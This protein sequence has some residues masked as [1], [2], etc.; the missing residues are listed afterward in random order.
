VRR[1]PASSLAQFSPAIESDPPSLYVERHQ[2]IDW[3]AYERQARRLHGRRVWFL[4][5]HA[6]SDE[7]ERF[8]KVAFPRF[9][10]TIGH[11][12]D[13]YIGRGAR[14]FLYDLR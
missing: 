7:E 3:A 12:E 4:S 13:T 11:R 1:S 9:L 6:S 14:V 5:T 10:D 2:G 8:E